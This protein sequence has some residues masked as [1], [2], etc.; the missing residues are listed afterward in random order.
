MGG[1][2]V[3]E[4]SDEVGAV[5]AALSVGKGLTFEEVQEKFNLTQTTAS[6]LLRYLR[7]AS[8]NLVIKR[9]GG[10]I[11]ASY[12]SLRPEFNVTVDVKQML[13]IKS[14]GYKPGKA[15]EILKAG[16]APSMSKPSHEGAE[17]IWPKAP[18]IPDLKEEYGY[19]VKPDYHDQV[20]EHLFVDGH[21]L[22][23][24]G[25]P[26][27]GKS[28]I[29]E[30]ITATERIPLANVNAES[31]LR[32][33]DMIGHITDLG[34][35]E[36]A[37]FAAAV[38]FGWHAKLDEANAMETDAAMALNSI[39]APPRRIII[40]GHSYPVHPKFRLALTYNPGLAGT[41]PLPDS[42]KNRLY[43]VKVP[44]PSESMLFKMMKSNGVDIA[45]PKAKNLIN[46]GLA[47]NAARE[48]RDTNFQITPRDLLY[49]WSDIKRGKSTDKAITMAIINGIDGQTDAAAVHNLM[50]VSS[51]S[52]V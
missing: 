43:P 42:L 20:Y 15:A 14:N 8:T 30:V 10:R 6:Q 7:R 49:A 37:E 35:F 13:P 46:F 48:A 50:V 16:S 47:C 9:R 45:D 32:Y 51:K 39:L 36:V 17:L 52:W 24:S 34:T 12:K 22:R 2:Y 27:S 40:H 1:N 3:V 29:Y 38:V 18:E 33:K 11:T 19:Y 21:N 23:F 26:G 31:G 5:I 4:L 44:F 25:P 28:S 41:K